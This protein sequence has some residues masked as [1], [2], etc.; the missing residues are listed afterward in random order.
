MAAAPAADAFAVSAAAG[1]ATAPVVAALSGEVALVSLP[2]NLLAAPAVR[3]RLLPPAS[4]A[5]HPG[6]RAW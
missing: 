2:A 5:G 6:E 3:A 1:L 4:A